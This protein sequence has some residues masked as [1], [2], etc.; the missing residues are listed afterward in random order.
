VHGGQRYLIGPRHP[1]NSYAIIAAPAANDTAMKCLDTG[2][3]ADNG[4]L[5]LQVCQPWLASQRF[6]RAAFTGVTTPSFSS[7]GRYLTITSRSTGLLVEVSA[8]STTPGAHVQ[9]WSL[10]EPAA[11]NQAWQLSHEIDNSWS[12]VN[13][14]SGQCLDVTGFGT[15]PG[16]AIQ[17]YPC[18]HTSNQKWSFSSVPDGSWAIVNQGSKLCL[19]AQSSQ[20]GQLV[21]ASCDVT[22]AGYKDLR[23]TITG[24]VFTRFAANTSAWSSPIHA[25]DQYVTSIHLLDSDPLVL[26]TTAQAWRF[27]PRSALFGAWDQQSL[28]LKL[29]GRCLEGGVLEPYCHALELS[30]WRFGPKN[31]QGKYS[32]VYGDDDG[33][34]HQCLDASGSAVTVTTCNAQASSQWFSFDTVPR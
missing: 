19:Q 31:G 1:D 32:L 3:A 12:L 18:A 30:S 4:A 23:F 13:V 25:G 5:S 33:S 29:G 16:V 2:K 21:Q 10:V 34:G 7:A 15:Q 27:E 24:G 9:G 22:S 26:S 11:A 8:S 6:K 14:N 28:H 20:G 17:Q